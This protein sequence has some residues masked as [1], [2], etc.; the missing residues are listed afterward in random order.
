[1]TQCDSNLDNTNSYVP[2]PV[3]ASSWYPN[4][5]ATHNVYQNVFGLNALTSY[6]VLASHGILHYLSYPY[7]LEK[8]GFAKR[9]HKHIVETGHTLLAQASLLMDYWGYAFSSAVHLINRL[10][11]SVLKRYSTQ[12]KGYHCLTPDGK[13]GTVASSVTSSPLQI[14]S[15]ASS[16]ESLSDL[17]EHNPS[18][19][20]I[21]LLTESLTIPH[22]FP[23]NTHAMITQ[24]KARIFKPK[25]LTV[26][27]IDFEPRSVE[28]AFTHKEWKLAV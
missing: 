24:F 22:V 15:L 19:E 8:N 11:T 25:T 1:A 6:T 2:V 21:Q 10:P 18:T 20:A 9:K 14:V 17:R 3:A 27:A 12:Y 26:E 23:G 5:G 4:S 13:S 7:T 16:T 28:V